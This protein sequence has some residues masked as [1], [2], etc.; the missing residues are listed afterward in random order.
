MSV[1]DFD[2]RFGLGPSIEEERNRFVARIENLIFDR[3][4]ELDEYY[5][6]FE[7]VC[8]QLGF[9]ALEIIEN[10]SFYRLTIPNLDVL[11]EKDFIQTLRVVVAIYQG[12]KNKPKRQIEIDQLVKQVFDSLQLNIGVR[13]TDGS[14]Y[15]SGDEFLDKELI[16]ISISLLDKYPNEKIDLARA[17]ENYQS[18]RSDGV[19]ENCYR[20]IEGLSRTILKNKRTL[21]N[22]KTDFLRKMQ[23]SDIWSRIF[24]NYIEYAHEYGRHASQIRHELKP[25]EVEAYLY[26]TCLIVRSTIKAYESRSDPSDNMKEHF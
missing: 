17:L 6:L 4:V 1:K 12:F 25:E 5:E 7:S 9:N 2:K 16:G 14:F 24:A 3:L 8:F 13:W 10:N 20:C 15:P 19:V 21:D 26:L 18:G 23:F 22:N 11:T